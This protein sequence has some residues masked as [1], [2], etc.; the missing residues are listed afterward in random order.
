MEPGRLLGFIT[1]ARVRDGSRSMEFKKV[2]A[3]CPFRRS[4]S[5]SGDQFCDEAG[6]ISRV[7]GSGVCG[8]AAWSFLTGH[9]L[10]S[11]SGVSGV[12][13]TWEYIRFSSNLCASVRTDSSCGIGGSMN[14]ELK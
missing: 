6:R 9:G 14:G 10:H 1:R 2:G 11:Q 13:K 7:I 12:G 5:V 8:A 3:N 4:F